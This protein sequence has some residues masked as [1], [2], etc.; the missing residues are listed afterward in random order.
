V[1]LIILDTLSSSGV[2][3]DENNN[4]EAATVMKAFAA[5][6]VE[7]NALF[8]I[9]HHPPKSGDGERGAG[10]IRNNADY[11]M[12]IKRE[13][14]SAV[15]E[16]EMSKSRDAETRSFGTFTLVPVV[17][18]HD[19][20]GKEIKTM[21][22]SAGEPR[23]RETRAGQAHA[24]DAIQA[25]EFSLVENTV[26]IDGVAWTPEAHAAENFIEFWKGKGNASSI[27]RQFNAAVRYAIDMGALEALKQ[28]NQVYLKRKEM[29]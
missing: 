3:S 9:L 16:I 13:G 22:V 19:D 21:T 5:L 27:T 8:L 12:S 11:V 23:I 1:R 20:D 14:T 18:G 6:S 29:L 17:I 4:A 28:D 26:L 2:L 10:A 7:M 15:R 24:E 25:V